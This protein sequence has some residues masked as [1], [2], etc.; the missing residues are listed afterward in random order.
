MEQ[1]FWHIEGYDSST[2]IYDKK[3]KVG[4]FS[5]NQIKNLLK[6]LTAKAGLSYDEIVGAYAKK[7]TKILNELLIIQRDG[8]SQ[9]YTCGSN[10]HFI[11]RVI[12]E[13]L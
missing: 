2:K 8:P 10:P 13:E 5:D 7:N 11:A 4:C 9:V 6:A 1:R 12:V 3:V